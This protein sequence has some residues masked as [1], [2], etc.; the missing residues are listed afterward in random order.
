MKKV[1]SLIIVV[2]MIVS[3]LV[4]FTGSSVSEKIIPSL[5]ISANNISYAV[6]NSLYGISLEN[7]GNAVDG[8]LIS[9]LVNNN[10]FEYSNNPVAA[11]EISAET[12]SV[13][14]EEG[15]NENNK[16]YLSVTVNGQGKVEN[17]G[18]SEVYNYKSYQVNSKK[19][20]EPDMPF[21]ATEI[22]RFSAYFKNIDYTGTLTAS[23]NAQGNKEKYQFNID[24]CNEWTLISLEIRSDVT[25]DGSLL[26]SF[27]GE[28]S[29][30]MDYVTLVPM[31]SYG[32]G[33]DEWQYVSLRSDLVKSIY[34]LS[35]SFIRFRAG[36]FDKSTNIEE[37]GSWKDTIGPL[38]TR[39]QSFIHTS[40]NVFSVN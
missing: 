26:I 6:S 16:N 32:C 38:E 36:E 22:Y 1:I 27:E 39:K 23:L 11:W 17:T 25:D 29:F 34:T 13:L 3:V 24:T 5:N 33:S 30:Y 12:Y 28:G 14:S 10:S 40:K 31:S 37:L 19:A 35:P 18:Y 2:M 15:L 9:N 7:T 8:G 21:K 20:T 4:S